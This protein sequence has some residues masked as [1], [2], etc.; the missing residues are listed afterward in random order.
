MVA[1]YQ[2]VKGNEMINSELGHVK[3]LEEFKLINNF[4]KLLKYKT[5]TNQNLINYK[6]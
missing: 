3:T 2:Y 5:K 6:L 4:N 1:K